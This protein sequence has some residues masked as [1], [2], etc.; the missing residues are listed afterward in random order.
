[1]LIHFNNLIT[2]FT[3]P[4]S[5]CCCYLLNYISKILNWLYCK[6]YMKTQPLCVM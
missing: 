5:Y 1:M 4:S 6:F 2:V 3:L